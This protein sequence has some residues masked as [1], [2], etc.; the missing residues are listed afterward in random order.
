M[1]IILKLDSIKIKEKNSFQSFITVPTILKNKTKSTKYNSFITNKKLI[2]N[3][4]LAS[5]TKQ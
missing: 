3:I 4:T 1:I 2:Y 5:K